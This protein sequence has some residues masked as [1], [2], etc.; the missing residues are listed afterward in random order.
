MLEHFRS[1][2]EGELPQVVIEGVVYVAQDV[3]IEAFCVLGSEHGALVIGAG[4]TIR[5]HSVLEGGV[6]I[7]PR[8]ECGHH[9]LIRHGVVIGPDCRVGSYSSI[10]GGTTLHEGVQLGGRVQMGSQYPDGARLQIGPR[11]RIYLGAL[12]LDN[13][14]PPDPEHYAIPLI[15][16]D[17]SIGAGAIILPGAHVRAG[18]RVRA[19]EVVR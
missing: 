19:G 18:R 6:D 15:E 4:S 17:C 1:L 13:P 16:E 9:V 12:V 3:M 7:G 5:S 2:R 14:K 8:F 11:T 10:E